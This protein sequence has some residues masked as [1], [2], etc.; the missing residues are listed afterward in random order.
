MILRTASGSALR[1]E[2]RKTSFSSSEI[3]LMA[4]GQG[5]KSCFNEALRE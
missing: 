5:S 4:K 2:V 1:T 3:F